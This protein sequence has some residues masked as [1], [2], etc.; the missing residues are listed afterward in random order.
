MKIM[1]VLLACSSVAIEMN[2]GRNTDNRSR[3]T[4]N[5]RLDAHSDILWRKA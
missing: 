5:T 2:H 3:Q 4:C 1:N